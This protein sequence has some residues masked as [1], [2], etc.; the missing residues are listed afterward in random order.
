MSKNSPSYDKIDYDNFSKYFDHTYLKHDANASTIH[1][2]CFEARDFGFASVCVNPYFVSIASEFLNGSPVAV[3]TVID[4]P[5]GSSFPEIR[6]AEA[7][8]ALKNGAREL[9]VVLLL[10]AFLSGD[11]DTSKRDIQRIVSIAKKYGAI[12]KVIIETAHLT[13]LQKIDACRLASEAGA[14]FVKTSTGF[15]PKGA[16][17]EDVRLMREV[18]PAEIKIKAAGGIKSADFAIELVNAGA[19]RIGASAGVEIIRQA[20]EILNK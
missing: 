20:Q 16:T 1:K 6:A 2:L 17:V 13:K 19:D 3:S 14:N 10:P 8:T 7:E 4:F 15:A 9:D 18:C 12:V 11:R 5:L